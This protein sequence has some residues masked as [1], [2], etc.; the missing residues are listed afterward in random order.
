VTGQVSIEGIAYLVFGA[1]PLVIALAG[2]LLF[3]EEVESKILPAMAHAFLHPVVAVI[4]VVALLSA[5]LSTIDSAILSPASVLAQNV[6]PRFGFSDT[7]SSN[8]I[9]VLLVAGCSLFVAFQ[10][11]DAFDLL[12][13]SYSLTLV[14]LFIPLMI[15]LYSRPRHRYAANAAM[16][17]G[18]SLWVIHYLQEWDY[19]FE[20]VPRIGALQLPHE[21]S[22][23]VCAPLAYF[24][25][26][27]RW[28]INWARTGTDAANLTVSSWKG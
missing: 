21:L 1:I 19:F 27:P 12:S 8:R 7:L 18:S 23:T 28:R 3:P 13:E 6:F 16:L 10:N 9:A 15:G 20:A 22:A 25:C 14:G 5:I 4:F 17:T 24:I 11:N 26:E 2:N